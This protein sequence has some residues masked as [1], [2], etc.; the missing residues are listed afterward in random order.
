[1]LIKLAATTPTLLLNPNPKR[2]KYSVQMQAVI[3]DTNNTGS[4]FIGIGFQPTAT[5]GTPLQGEI[6]VQGVLIER[7]RVGE[8][9]TDREKGAIWAVSDTA[10]QTILVEEESEL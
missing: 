5:V 4:I 9:L 7:P 3:V 2:I 8:K 10:D 1:M 6:L